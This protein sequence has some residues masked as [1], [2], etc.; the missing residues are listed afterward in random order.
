MARKPRDSAYV[1]A[2]G[3]RLAEVLDELDIPI[4]QLGKDLGYRDGSTLYAAAAGRCL[5]D[6][7]RLVRL[8][9]W[10]QARSHPLNLHW[11]LTGESDDTE[12]ERQASR[13]ARWLTPTRQAALK[14][15]AAATDELPRSAN[16]RRPRR[17]TPMKRQ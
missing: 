9:D 8:S 12:R 14:V 3:Q 16:R 17:I 7:E 1:S 10:C 11:L 5:L 15:L 2:F 4:A 13:I 6:V